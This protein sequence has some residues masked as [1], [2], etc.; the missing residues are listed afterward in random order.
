MPRGVRV[1][2][3][4]PAGEELPPCLVL[5]QRWHAHHPLPESARAPLP[6]EP[7]AS[8]H[9]DTDTDTE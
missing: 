3:R 7:C 8:P 5:L 2:V 4:G 9:T 1:A 6:S